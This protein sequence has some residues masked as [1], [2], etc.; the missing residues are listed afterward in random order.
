MIA[1]Y[2]PETLEFTRDIFEDIAEDSEVFC[3]RITQHYTYL[4]AKGGYMPIIQE[5]HLY[6]AWDAFCHDKNH[7]ADS[8]HPES[9]GKPDHFKLSGILA[10]W[11]R[12]ST[13]VCGLRNLNLVHQK[14]PIFQ[15]LLK[16]YPSELSAFDMGLF[17]CSRFETERVDNSSSYVP[18]IEANNFD[19]YRDICFLLK[20]KSLSPHSLGMIYR[21]LFVP[22]RDKKAAEYF[23][24]EDR[25]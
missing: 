10:Y 15:E 24:L 4:F 20:R 21:S 22:L 9:K 2:R 23:P 7:A 3:E 5:K 17:I 8:L 18:A 12:R 19:Y 25:K 13:P 1:P 6:D 14:Y 11:L 16:K